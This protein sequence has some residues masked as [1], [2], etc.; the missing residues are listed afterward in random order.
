MIHTYWLKKLTALH[1]RLAAKMNQLLQ[2]GIQ[3]ECLTQYL[4]VLIMEESPEWSDTI[5]LQA[6]NL[7][8]H[9]M[10]FPIKHHSS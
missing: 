4:T 10:D 1:E 8:H 7:R 9:D 6:Y 3:P 2:S 5:Q